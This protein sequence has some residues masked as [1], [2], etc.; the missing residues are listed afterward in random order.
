MSFSGPGTTTGVIR[1]SGPGRYQNPARA[2]RGLAVARDT[3]RPRQAEGDLPN[4][5][6]NAAVKWLWLEKPKSNARPLK[7]RT[8]QARGLRE[9]R[10]R[11]RV[12]YAWIG[13]PV[14]LRNTRQRCA[15]V[16]P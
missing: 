15:G 5:R 9:A 6:R 2:A 4:S 3:A 16:T 11:R 10:R 13:Q 14:T 7:S 12:R 1:R 8:P